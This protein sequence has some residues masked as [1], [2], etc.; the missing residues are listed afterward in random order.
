MTMTNPTD[1]ELNAAFAEKVCG[2]ETGP[3]GYGD[4]DKYYEKT[5]PHHSPGYT[6]KFPFTTSVDAV[7]PWLEKWHAEIGHLLT[8]GWL[9]LLKES[10]ISEKYVA[11]SCLS[12]PRAAVIALLRAHGVEVIFTEGKG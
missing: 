6:Y 10:A 12:F 4:G 9:V 8:S 2:W 1:K 11:A 3:D 5:P 7:L